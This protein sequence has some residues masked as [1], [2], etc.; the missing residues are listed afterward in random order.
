VR[1][2]L[3]RPY[4]VVTSALAPSIPLVPRG[5][6]WIRCGRATERNFRHKVAQHG[7]SV[8]NGSPSPELT[9][10]DLHIDIVSALGERLA[11][12]FGRDQVFLDISAIR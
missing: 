4:P 8:P 2:E 7:T 12:H 5:V 3:Q 11:E 1:T 10:R 9:D 6:G